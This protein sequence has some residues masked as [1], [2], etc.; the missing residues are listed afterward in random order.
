MQTWRCS[1]KACNW[2]KSS[3]LIHQLSGTMHLDLVKLQAEYGANGSYRKA[4]DGLART[5]GK[6]RINNHSRIRHVTN[7]VG[8]ILAEHSLTDEGQI[9]ETAEEYSKCCSQG[10]G[11]ITNDL[12][13]TQLE[14]GHLDFPEDNDK[15]AAELLC[16]AVDGGHVHDA[17]NSGKNFE[18]MMG[19]IFDPNNIVRLDKH[20]TKITKKHCAGSVK[21][22]KQKTMKANLVKAAN[23]EGINKKKT[24]LIALADGAK[25]CWNVIKALEPLC[26]LL[27]CIL[28]WFHIGKYIKRVKVKLPNLEPQLD[29]IK[30]LLWHGHVEEALVK[31]KVLLNT[32]THKEHLRIVNNFYEYIFENKKYIV[33]YGQ[34]RDKG[35][36]YTSHVAESTVEHLLN[37]RCKRKQKMQWSR[38]GI[39][40]VIQIR[41]SQASGDWDNDWGNIIKPKYLAAA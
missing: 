23:A 24:K 9:L 31:I 10:K 12:A 33:D 3:S 18:V 20:H 17:N 5:T 4:A 39:H 36:P 14:K 37:D 11:N 28:D 38:D 13:H 16:A 26:L 8:N 2:N 21:Y 1:N 25:N 7:A 19:K 32:V 34:R 35:L 6:R 40:A 41:V 27:V 15:I 29:E 30:S 22:D